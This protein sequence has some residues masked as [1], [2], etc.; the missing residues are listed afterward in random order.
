MEISITSLERVPTE[1]AVLLRFLEALND[2]ELRYY[3]QDWMKS[4]G[5]ENVDELNSAISPLIDAMNSVHMSTSENIKPVYICNKGNVYRDWKLSRLGLTYLAL[6]SPH[7]TKKISQLQLKI[8]SK[9]FNS[10]V[11]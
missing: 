2:H 7:K 10:E 9:Y 3:A 8:L 4:I 11:H 6:N 5:Y 1:S